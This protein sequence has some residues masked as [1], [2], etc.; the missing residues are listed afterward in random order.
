MGEKIEISDCEIWCRLQVWEGHY[1]YMRI[2]PQWRK[3]RGRKMWE[4]EIGPIKTSRYSLGQ[5][6]IC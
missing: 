6:I 2:Q 4:S 3:N 5:Q 1:L